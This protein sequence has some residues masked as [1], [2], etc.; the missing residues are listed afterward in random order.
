METV[1]KRGANR[2]PEFPKEDPK[3]RIIPSNIRLEKALWERLDHVAKV[4]GVSRNEVIV[5][6]LTWACNDWELIQQRKKK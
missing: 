1:M 3:K 4:E 2:L 5:Y 6:F